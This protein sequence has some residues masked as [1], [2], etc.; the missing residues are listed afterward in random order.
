MKK[1][2]IIT[3]TKSEG[4]KFTNRY[5]SGQVQSHS[6]ILP[7][8]RRGKW[9]STEDEDRENV[10]ASFDALDGVSLVDCRDVEPPPQPQ[11]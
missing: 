8:P 1:S 5:G 6:S 9:K 2:E 3:N 10:P 11:P 4:A 7:Q